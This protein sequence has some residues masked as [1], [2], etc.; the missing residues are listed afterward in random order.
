VGIL[1]AII[2]F[3]IN[4]SRMDVIKSNLSGRFYHSTVERSANEEEVLRRYGDQLQIF[5]LQG[6]IF[7]GTAER[8]LVR[9]RR[10][11][12]RNQSDPNRRVLFIV[13]DFRLVQNIDSSAL[14]AFTKLLTTAKEKG[15]TL[16]F[17]D[18]NQNIKTQFESAG[19]FDK[20]YAVHFESLDFG[21]EWCEGQLIHAKAPPALQQTDIKGLL[22]D[23]LQQSE[24]VRKFNEFLELFSVHK[25]EVLFQMGDPSD[26]LY[27][28]ESG[29]VSVLLHK[30]NGQAHRFRTMGPGTVIGE[31]GLYTEQRRTAKAIA[32]EDSTL[33]V[34]SYARFMEIED[35]F[36]DIARQFHK[37]VVRSLSTRMTRD[38]EA[39]QVLLV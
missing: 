8:L 32:D 37:F 12:S 38:S 7:F 13:L 17:S 36:P 1:I 33:Y 16:V 10:S 24:M 3:V 27:F 29:R 22:V 39:I 25:N 15:C 9:I 34:L 23:I 11:I 5:I 30:S 21:L 28:I 26:C 18:L 4:Y 14:N 19:Y 35:R 20:D 2:L 31:M 6:F